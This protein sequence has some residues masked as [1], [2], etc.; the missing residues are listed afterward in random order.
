MKV[1]NVTSVF[2]ESFRNC[3]KTHVVLV[4]INYASTERGNRKALKYFGGRGQGTV[5]LLRLDF[6]R[7]RDCATSICFL[8]TFIRFFDSTEVVTGIGLL[9]II[10]VPDETRVVFLCLA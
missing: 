8:W 6:I 1:F 2:L 9:V 4:L 3:L 7:K 5:N 10:F